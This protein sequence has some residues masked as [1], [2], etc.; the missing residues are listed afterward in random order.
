MALEGMY[1]GFVGAVLYFTAALSDPSQGKI[2]FRP[3]TFEYVIQIMLDK[4]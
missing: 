4:L 3:D 1:A 2:G